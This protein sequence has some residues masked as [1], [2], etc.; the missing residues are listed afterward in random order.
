MEDTAPITHAQPIAPNHTAQVMP[1]PL[2]G[3]VHEEPSEKKPKA[4]KAKK[5]ATKPKVAPAP[6]AKPKAKKAAKK[7]AKK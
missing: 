2:V 7:I 3:L 4:T 6:A 1:P 5:A